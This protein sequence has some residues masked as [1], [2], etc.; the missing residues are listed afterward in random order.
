MD[1]SF[2]DRALGLRDEV[3]KVQLGAN[4][5]DLS[6]LARGESG[7]MEQP[8]ELPDDKIALAIM[9]RALGLFAEATAASESGANE[10]D[11][12][13][14]ADV[15]DLLAAASAPLPAFDEA[16][17]VNVG[18]PP[19]AEPPVVSQPPVGQP[20]VSQ[21]P[22]AQPPVSQPPIFQ[23]PVFQPPVS[24][25]PVTPPPIGT[26]GIDVIGRDADPYA[27]EEPKAKP[28]AKRASPKKK[29][30]GGRRKKGE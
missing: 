25:P 9:G 13:S 14:R 16:D 29:R 10:P 12:Q 21:P 30:G 4:A 27:P 26:G 8:A 5:P 3:Q 22:I 17:F 28:R 2:I 7:K 20:P 11:P 24:Q 19:V 1:V 23:P 6:P 18:T 15:A